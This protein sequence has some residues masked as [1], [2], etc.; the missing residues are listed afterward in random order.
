MHGEICFSKDFYS[1]FYLFIYIY[2]IPEVFIVIFT[3]SKGTLIKQRGGL[4]AH[5]IY[6]NE[7]PSNV[8]LNINEQDD[9]HYLVSFCWTLLILQFYFNI[10]WLLKKNKQDD[11]VIKRISIQTYAFL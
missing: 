2:Y 11:G 8:F 7:C 1:E 6:S 3:Y 4:C 5:C 9:K 10:F